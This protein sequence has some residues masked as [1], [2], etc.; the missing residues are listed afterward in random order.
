MLDGGGG[1]GGREEATLRVWEFI[2]GVVI[3]VVRSG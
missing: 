2:T 1:L 3:G